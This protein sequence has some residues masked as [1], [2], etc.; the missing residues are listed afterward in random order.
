MEAERRKVLDM[1]AEGKVTADE[2]ERLLHG[3]WTDRGRVPETDDGDG[4][5]AGGT[6]RAPETRRRERTARMPAG[7]R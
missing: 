1:V 6:P 5:G 2:A 4:A 7:L 3:S